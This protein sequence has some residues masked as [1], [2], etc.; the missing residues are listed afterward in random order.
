MILKLLLPLSLSLIMFSIGLTLLVDDFRRVRRAPRAIGYGLFSQM[1]LLPLLAFGVVGLLDLPAAA[2]IGVIILAASPGGITSNLLTHL[3]DGDSALSISLT[4]LTSLAGVVTV[5]LMVNLGLYWYGAP[6]AELPVGRMVL[7]VLLISTLP[8]LLGMLLRHR[9]PRATGRL[10]PFARRVAT[11]LFVVIVVATFMSHWDDIGQQFSVAGP[12][13][14]GLNL[15]TMG[16]ALVG[17]RLLRLQRR[18]RIAIT[19]EC[20]LQNAA[21]GIFVAVSLLGSELL[22]LPSIIYALVMNA[23]AL[24]FIAA[25]LL[26]VGRP[27]FSR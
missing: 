19:L 16:L 23:S 17:G 27:L 5:P 13:V 20:G 7:G 25:C 15:A 9:W 21:M 18:Q 3:A 6:T 26:P 24:L 1:L 14:V 12:A 22:A 2:A 10:Q 4:A 11:F 8:L